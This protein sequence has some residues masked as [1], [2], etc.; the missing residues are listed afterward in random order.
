MGEVN[1]YDYSSTTGTSCTHQ[2]ATGGIVC[3]NDELIYRE[4]ECM[5]TVFNNLDESSNVKEKKIKC[6]NHP[7]HITLFFFL[8]RDVKM[9][10]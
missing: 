9:L 4:N 5:I 1:K 6:Q 3:L 10:T 8:K 2:E 7:F